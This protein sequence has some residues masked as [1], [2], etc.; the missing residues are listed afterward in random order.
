MFNK[1]QYNLPFSSFLCTQQP[2]K[3]LNTL[4][5]STVTATN[6]GE[7]NRIPALPLWLGQYPWHFLE[8]ASEPQHLTYLL[9]LQYEHY[10]LTPRWMKIL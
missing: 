3:S 10:Q 4:V 9:L 7:R 6:L 2:H 5:Q 1:V 8:T